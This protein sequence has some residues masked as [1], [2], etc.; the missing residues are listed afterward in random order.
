MMPSVMARPADGPPMFL[1]WT[2]TSTGKCQSCCVCGSIPRYAVGLVGAPQAVL[3]SPLGGVPSVT[4]LVTIGPF[5]KSPKLLMEE[6]STL[7][8]TRWPGVNPLSAPIREQSLVTGVVFTAVI[9]CATCREAAAGEFAVIPKMSAPAFVDFTEYP[10]WDSAAA[11]ANDWAWAISRYPWS[12]YWFSFV[13]GPSSSVPE[14]TWLSES[15]K[16]YCR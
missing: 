13:V 4:D 8:A 11:M 6:S 3:T 12:R 9:T 5:T 7:S 1:V 2:V 14:I 10:R 16:R 15:K